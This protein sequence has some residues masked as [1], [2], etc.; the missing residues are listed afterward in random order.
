MARGGRTETLSIGLVVI[1]GLAD[2]IIFR[3]GPRDDGLNVVTLGIDWWHSSSNTRVPASILPGHGT[4]QELDRYQDPELNGHPRKVA[5]TQRKVSK[6][7]G[8]YHMPKQPRDQ[9]L[10]VMFWLAPNETP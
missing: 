1:K 4:Q 3:S 5:D 2:P 8:S 6:N 10:I 9:G 7:N